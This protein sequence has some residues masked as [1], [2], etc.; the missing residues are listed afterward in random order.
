MVT[1]AFV[2]SNGTLPWLISDGRIDPFGSFPSTTFQSAVVPFTKTLLLASKGSRRTPRFLTSNF[3]EPLTSCVGN[4]TPTISPTTARSIF[5]PNPPL[6]PVLSHM[7][8]M[9]AV[10]HSL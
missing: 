2:F 4:P 5:M 1:P 10:G 7:P 3:P 6:G 8:K 9:R